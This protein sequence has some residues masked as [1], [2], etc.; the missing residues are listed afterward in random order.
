MPRA[1]G[2][3]PVVIFNRKDDLQ[4]AFLRRLGAASTGVR[5][6]V[7]ATDAFLEAVELG[8]GWGLIPDVQA[9]GRTGAPLVDIVPG[10]AVE[11]PLHW[12][13]WKFA[14][15]ALTAVGDAVAARAAEVLVP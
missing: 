4:D 9:A 3:A 8:L 15:P 5:H 6:Y 11:V 1:L 7:P 10:Q 14:S 13:Q 12:Q 2:A